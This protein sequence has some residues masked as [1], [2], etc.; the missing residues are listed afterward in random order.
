MPQIEKTWEIQT[1]IHGCS[2]REDRIQLNATFTLTDKMYHI[3]LVSG[4]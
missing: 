2:L 1:F 4:A 3:P